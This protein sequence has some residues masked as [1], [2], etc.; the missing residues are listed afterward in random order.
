M[1]K[2]CTTLLHF[3][4][5]QLWQEN[6]RELDAPHT[7]H[8]LSTRS[9]EHSSWVS[10]NCE[11]AQRTGP[12]C[13]EVPLHS[14]SACGSLRPLTLTPAGIAAKA[15]TD[16]QWHWDSSEGNS[17]TLAWYQV[18]MVQLV[19][20]LKSWV[21]LILEIKGNSN[22]PSGVR[23]NG[24]QLVWGPVWGESTQVWIHTHVSRYLDSIHTYIGT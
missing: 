7:F 11:L 16:R 20:T 8:N 22:T 6:R 15:I 9:G 1:H 21:P 5:Y 2:F 13:S 19:I 12:L 14:H 3:L 4:Q 10:P 23:F 17:E 18:Q 24:D